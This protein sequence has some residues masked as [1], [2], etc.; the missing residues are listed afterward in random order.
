[1]K[2]IRLS[3]LAATTLSSLFIGQT[4]FS[5]A[6]QLYELGT[7]II[8]TAAVG[9]AVVTDDASAS[10]FNP[11]GMSQLTNSHFM[12]GSQAIL[13][14]MNFSINKHQ[15]TIS[16]DNGGNA[17]SLTPGLNLYYAQALS[18]CWRLGISF[19]SPY[20]GLLNYD[21]G[22]VGRYNTQNLQ[23]IVLDLNPVISYKI[24]DNFSIGGGV[25]V[26]Y[27]SLY[28]TLA[29]PFRRDDDGQANIKVDNTSPGINLGV[30]FTPACGTKVGLTYRTQI[31]HK[32]RGKTTFLRIGVTPAT[33][34]QITIPANLM[35]SVA[36]EI[37]YQLTLL[38]ELG[39]TNWSSMKSNTINIARFSPST[40]LNWKNTYRIGVASQYIMNPTLLLQAG[41][42]Y[43][44]SP[45]KVT[46]R[47]P[48]LPADKQLRIGAGFI[49][50]I[51]QAAR[52]GFS[53]EYANYGKAAM[54]RE[55][56]IGNFSGSYR[57]NF[58]NTVQTSIDVD[59]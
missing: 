40:I 1:M 30:L 25:V 23:L 58:L 4:A 59:L 5:A 2:S 18:P 12:L 35:F 19:T 39:W 32:L 57:R 34:T 16:G 33:S 20:G 44:S 14:Y 28:Q 38:G 13:P 41:I 21:N 42:S 56:L 36:K 49:Y 50:A 7:P 55:G 17:G 47:T 27:A 37:T 15:T 24:N 3:L 31:K 48:N 26:E 52:I 29:L 51:C 6:F 45:T 46:R 11:A 8:G 43:D 10:Y 54:K 9:Q 53:Y 22:W